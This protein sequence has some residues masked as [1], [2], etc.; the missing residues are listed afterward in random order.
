MKT[1]CGPL[2]RLCDDIRAEHAEWLTTK[3][4]SVAKVSLVDLAL[5]RISRY[6]LRVWSTCWCGRAHFSEL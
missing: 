2:L 3:F 6:S 4:A 1:L 5:V